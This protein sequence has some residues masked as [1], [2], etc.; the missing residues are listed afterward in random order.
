MMDG[1][2]DRLKELIQ[3]HNSNPYALEKAWGLGNGT[4]WNAVNRFKI[5][6]IR[7]LIIIAENANVTLDWLVLGKGNKHGD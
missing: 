7:V 3:D 5:P 1:F 4:L 2:A 6:T